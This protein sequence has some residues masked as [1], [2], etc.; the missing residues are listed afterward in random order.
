M[1]A[2]N[3]TSCADRNKPCQIDPN[4][5]PMTWHMHQNA[6]VRDALEATQKQLLAS[7]SQL[8]V[9][10]AQLFAQKPWLTK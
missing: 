3:C 8:A 6:N 7:Q 1:P 4:K 10:H 9:L 5:T 2:L